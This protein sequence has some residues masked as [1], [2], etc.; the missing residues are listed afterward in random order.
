M[1]GCECDFSE[2]SIF[3]PQILERYFF[4]NFLE[5]VVI[6]STDRELFKNPKIIEFD[7]ETK[8]LQHFEVGQILVFS[9]FS[10]IFVQEIWEI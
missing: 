6:E 5:T 9:N 1:W 7:P 4:R 8:K 10:W 3:Q 2:I